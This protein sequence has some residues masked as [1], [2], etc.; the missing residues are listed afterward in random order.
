M[1][2]LFRAFVLVKDNFYFALSAEISF[3]LTRRGWLEFF[4]E[5]QFVAKIK[6]LGW[7][8]QTARMFITF[9]KIYFEKMRP[10]LIIFQNFVKT[11]YRLNLEAVFQLKNFEAIKL[12]NAIL[13][14]LHS[15]ACM[16]LN[17][18]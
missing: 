11:F 12:S 1:R 15:Y 16:K 13:T 14:L 8:S 18:S 4:N 6:E 7:Y 10:E 17:D 9:I 3:C 5:A 2:R